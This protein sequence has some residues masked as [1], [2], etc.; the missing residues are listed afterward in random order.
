MR[1]LLYDE[2][3]LF[4]SPPPS[5]TIGHGSVPFHFMAAQY[6][7]GASGVSLGSNIGLISP[8]SNQ[9]TANNQ[10]VQLTYT[11]DFPA[12]RRSRRWAFP[13][14]SWMTNPPRR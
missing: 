7:S 9:P 11:H 4:S 3:K 5:P 6:L 13:T 10:F 8:I 2:N 12:P 14:G 1:A